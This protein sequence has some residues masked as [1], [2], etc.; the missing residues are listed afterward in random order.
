MEKKIDFIKIAEIEVLEFKE[1]FKDSPHDKYL[2]IPLFIAIQKDMD[3]EM[4]NDAK[5]LEKAYECILILAFSSLAYK[6]YYDWY[7]II[8]IDKDGN[9]HDEFNK[10]GWAIKYTFSGDYKTKLMYLEYKEAQLFSVT[11][12]SYMTWDKPF[13]MIWDVYCYAHKSETLNEARLMIENYRLKQ[14][15]ES[16]QRKNEELCSINKALEEDMNHY[17]GLLDDISNIVKNYK[18]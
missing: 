9:I 11:K 10:D 6:N 3:I 4:S 16:L 14:N 18:D 13:K 15:N 7:K 12:E 5:I 17:K 1:S 8:F 2:D